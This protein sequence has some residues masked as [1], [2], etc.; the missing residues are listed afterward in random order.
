MAALKIPTF[1]YLNCGG[2]EFDGTNLLQ[3][4]LEWK[5]KR[6]PQFLAP[7]GCPSGS[8][9]TTRIS[10]GSGDQAARS[11]TTASSTGKPERVTRRRPSGVVS[12]AP[13]A[14]NV[15]MRF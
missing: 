10:E 3:L 13:S 2:H 7:C 4:Q 11:A 12:T 1:P 8:S 6:Y 14:C 5:L 9:F 15:A